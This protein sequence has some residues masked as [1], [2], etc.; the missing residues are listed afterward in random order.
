MVMNFD[1]LLRPKSNTSPTD[2]FEIFAKTPNL[3]NVPNDLWKGQAEALSL[4]HKNRTA[5]DNVILLNTG[6]GKSIVGVLMAQSLVNEAIGP[7][8]FA[9]ATIDLIEQTARECER[10]G[11][12]YTKRSQ[13]SFSND[14][15]ETGQAF[16]ITTYQA[17]FVANTTFNGT[18]APSA[19]IFDDA[20]VGERVIRDAFTLTI[21]KDQH[22][23]LFRDVIEI[24][25]PEFET[26]AK[27]PHLS[28]V[29]EQVGQQSVTMCP[30]STAFRHR[31]AILEAIKRTDWRKSDLMFPA[32][33]L[34]EYLGSCAIFVSASAIEITPPFIPTGVYDF[35]GQGVRRIYLSAT[36]EF[37][38]DFVRGFGRR[39]KNPI[40]PD[41]DAGN[42]E[43]LILLSSRFDDKVKKEELA[44]E[45]LKSHKLVI[46]VPSYPKAD[47][48]KNHG[49]PPSRANF[50]DELQAFREA[51]AGSFVLVSRIDGIDLPQDTCRV[52]LID[53][54]P[55]GASLM[56][57]Y[58]FQHMSLANLF[59]TKMAGRITQL[60]GRINRGR[61]DYSA[62]VI[63]GGDINV[64]LKT[65]RNIALLPPLVRKQF[66]LSQTVQE[67]MEKSSAGD[68][69]GLVTQVL[70]RDTGW[71]KF[72]RETVDGL[73]V[74]SEALEKV[75]ERESQLAASAEAECMFMTKL[76]QG[77]T[78]GARKALLDILDDTALAD[79]KLA[80]WYS[81]WL[82]A[83]YEADGD[84]ETAIAHYKKARARLSHWLNVPHRSEFDR[85][86]DDEG[87]K[88]LLQKRLLA[89]NHHGP[90][91]LGD[92]VS[93]L[94]M[95]AKLL[96][97]PASSSSLKE[98]A[99]RLYGELLGFSASRPDNEFGHGPD[100]VWKDDEAATL[101]AFELK[102]EKKE[103]AEYN[104]AEV[105]QA[106]NHIQWLKDNEK[107][108]R[109]EGLLLVG[110]SGVC[111]SE[112]SPS[113]DIFLVETRSLVAR[114]QTF[115]AKI[116]DTR[117]RTAIDR[118][119]LLNELGGLA[120]WQPNGFFGALAQKTL[121]SVKVD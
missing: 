70:A 76:W 112:A 9:C 3:K 67:G 42:G 50:T 75:K 93:K 74:S 104:K 110:P 58:L 97:D 46:S 71:M 52:M 108:V 72:Y 45:I 36:M 62:F 24:V 92:L 120:E 55:S 68:I 59:S 101:V 44:S 69:A 28:F 63:Y 14:L 90:Q 32:I 64:W 8:V 13:G 11:L 107:D 12:K 61:S 88:T 53:G 81:V 27:G 60:L 19:V 33:R 56:D 34:W 57:Q 39:A 117:G 15:F 7:V 91:A 20:H 98:E 38:T 109:S 121:K 83:S 23:G 77:D 95:Q 48:W 66:I 22:P 43:R 26:L 4:W 96:A 116:D 86:A 5:A 114:M 78:E 105:G 31:E 94:R 100:V 10:L 2:P 85:Q 41:N 80:G 54:A 82:A 29:L 49:T 17:L 87:D 21:G 47:V 111:K 89:V 106:H 18:K 119:T 35:L 51:T 73:E 115:A 103:P 102:T 25:R 16:C 113:E 30:P 118:W 99:V 65:E 84:S 1:S 37:E 40:V 6:A 79:A